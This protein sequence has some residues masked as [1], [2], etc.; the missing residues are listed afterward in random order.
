MPDKN[1]PQTT[2]YLLALE[3]SGANT[4]FALLQDNTLI[5]EVTTHLSPKYR[6]R[7]AHWI[8]HWL[9]ELN[10]SVD[11][12][13]GIA[14][15]TGPGSFTGL[16]VGMSV[17]K[18]LCVALNIPL[19]AVPTLEAMA[20]SMAISDKL[21]CPTTLARNQECYAALYK[22]SSE[23]IR[24]LSPPFSADAESLAERVTE[25]AW[26]WGEGA[27]NLKNDLLFLLS[28]NQEIIENDAYL[29][30]ASAIARWAVQAINRGLTPADPELEPF[31][32]KQFPG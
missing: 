6:D 7:L 12:L 32:L 13:S 10:I 31:Y 28:P 2:K 9:K 1:T 22:W 16:R 19:W 25:P 24:E 5:S 20:C 26:I 11:Q 18:G 27:M 15:S 23:G 30:K 21:L 8:D 14:V 3:T 4:S 17:A 29:P